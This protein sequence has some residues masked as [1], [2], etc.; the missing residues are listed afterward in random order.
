MKKLLVSVLLGSLLS[1]TVAVSQSHAQEDPLRRFYREGSAIS[2][3]AQWQLW[4]SFTPRQKSLAIAISRIADQH[5]QLY[6]Q[7]IPINLQSS[8]MMMRMIGAQP[9]E[10]AFV[11]NRMQAN[12]AAYASLGQVDATI[13]QM[14]NFLNCLQTRG[15]GCVP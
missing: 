12:Y 4:N 3:Q 2:Q 9:N 14:Y 15:T 13:N 11:V 1:M 5:W 8:Q 7:P 10:G 6:Q